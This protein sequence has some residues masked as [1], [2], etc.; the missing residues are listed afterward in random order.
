MS[1]WGWEVV[2]LFEF[3]QLVFA[4]SVSWLKVLGVASVV[5]GMVLMN[6]GD[7]KTS[8]QA[9]EPSAAGQV[10]VLSLADG[11]NAMPND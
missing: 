7:S 4:E 3:G 11:T 10:C 8:E 6:R 9:K 1:N 2:L 5:V